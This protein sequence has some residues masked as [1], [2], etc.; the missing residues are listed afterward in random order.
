M[1]T[2]LDLLSVAV[3]VIGCL[4]GLVFDVKT[5]RVPN[6]LTG[7]LLM[8]SFLLAALRVL[9]GDKSYM[10]TY[11]AS[12]TMGFVVGISLWFI[13]AW[14]GGD[15]KMFWALCALMPSRPEIFGSIFNA[16]QPY[17]ANYFFGITILF[18]LAILL[19]LRFFIAATFIFLRERRLRDFLEIL[20]TPIMLLAASSMF[21]IGIAH[22]TGVSYI[23]YASM[24]II[25]LLSALRKRSLLTYLLSSLALMVAGAVMAGVA[26][27]SSLTSLIKAEKTLF[28][29]T[30]ILSAYAAGS[31]VPLTREIRIRDLRRGMAIAE[32]IR[33]E[34]HR[35]VREDA[36]SS[37]WGYLSSRTMDLGK[38]KRDYIV[39]PMPSG[40]DDEDL[41][42][43]RLYEA[44][45]GGAVKINASFPLMPF[46]FAA[47]VL[48]FFADLFWLILS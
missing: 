37:L 48:S 10:L 21:G 13:Q 44:A 46:I 29:L 23:S 11:F 30:L 9:A 38:E 1:Y 33:I 45:L 20:M 34:D 41:E 12:F 6:K 8:I 15:A 35:L 19:L 40:L 47:V 5:K 42:K 36:N 27:I 7:S 26:D 25:P 22:I 32:E 4:A 2:L 14:S 31:A 18:N 17:Y 28:G 24:L 16:D 3:A 43:L 39:R